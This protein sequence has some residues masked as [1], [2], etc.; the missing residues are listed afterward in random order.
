MENIYRSPQGEKEIVSMYDTLLKQWPQPNAPRFVP[1]R[2][3]DTFVMQNGVAG[4]PPVLL[5][6][7]SSTNNALWMADAALLGQ[8]HCVFAVD[9]IGEPGKSAKSRPALS[10]G[11]YAN[12]LR[13]VMDG[14]GLQSAAIVGN[15]LGGWMALDFATVYPQR[16]DALI[17]LASGGICPVRVSLAFKALGCALR[18]KKGKTRFTALVTGDVP[19]SEEA[20]AFGALLQAHYVPRKVSPPVFEDGAL[21]KLTM[22]LLYVGGEHDVFYDSK[23]CAARLASLLPHADARVLPDMPHTLI[24]MGK[25]IRDFLEGTKNDD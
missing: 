17:L 2:F 6:H 21:K 25:E 14:L 22:P 8:M 20:Q 11:S 5:L 16:V 23:A 4:G 12:W 15:S 9:I 13:D 19:L 1:T 3:G 7:G 10:G 24:N 18:G